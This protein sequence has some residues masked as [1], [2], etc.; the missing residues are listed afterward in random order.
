MKER[1]RLEGM[2]ADL[3]ELLLDVRKELREQE[4]WEL[5]DTIRSRLQEMGVEI[6][7]QE[8]GTSWRVES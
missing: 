6:K 3:L 4:N 2:E 1:G 7:D 8:G 5:A